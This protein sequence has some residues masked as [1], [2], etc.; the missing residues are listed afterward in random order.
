[1]LVLLLGGGKR[2]G[3]VCHKVVFFFH[4]TIKRNKDID[5]R[6]IRDDLGKCK[7]VEIARREE[8]K[9]NKSSRER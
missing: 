4:G 1:M 2:S 6:E 8:E 7:K 5:Y 3:L 9:K